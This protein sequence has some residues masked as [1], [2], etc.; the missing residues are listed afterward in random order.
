MLLQQKISSLTLFTTTGSICQH[1]RVWVILTRH[2][3]LKP[4]PRHFQKRRIMT[5]KSWMG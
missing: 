2:C 5:L 1:W 3:H 4:R